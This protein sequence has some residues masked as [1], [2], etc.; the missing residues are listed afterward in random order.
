MCSSLYAQFAKPRYNIRCVRE[1]VFLGDIKVELFPLVAPLHTRNFDSLV[2]IQFYDST[3]FHRVVPNFVIQGGDPN[4]RH[5]DPST[6]G[7]GDSSQISIPAEFSNIIHARGTLGA[8]RDANI[9]SANSQ[10]FV[11][12]IENSGLNGL[13]TVYGK[14]YEGM[15]IVDSIALSPRVPGTERPVKKIEM[16]ITHIGYNNNVP[17]VPVPSSPPDGFSGATGGLLFEWPEIPEAVL[18]KLQVALDSGFT[19]LV[20]NNSIGRNITTIGSFEQGLKK[21]YWRVASN[22]G[23]SLSGYSPVRTFTTGIKPPTLISPPDSAEGVSI[24]PQF[25]W[26]ELPGAVGYRFQLA[27]SPSF[28]GSALIINQLITGVNYSVFNLAPNKRYYWR[29]RGIA[30]AYEGPLSATRTFM[31]AGAS[32]AGDESIPGQTK[33]LQNYPNPFNPETN[34]DFQ[35]AEPGYV[36]IEIFSLLGENVA[37]V[38][39]GEYSEGRHSIKFNAGYLPTGGYIYKLTTNHFSDKK[40]MLLVK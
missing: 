36:K 33:L 8:A 34:I 9:N 40:L 13:Y 5:G 19:N 22:N 23:G 39:D 32:D 2:T 20:Y 11:N 27:T 24:N 25:S 26:E 31:T 16:F 30:S 3:A 7:Y 10:F 18:Y 28:F 6:W 37:T 17:A 38:A 21:H 1:G 14:V 15:D 35:I 29:V 12:L 4:S